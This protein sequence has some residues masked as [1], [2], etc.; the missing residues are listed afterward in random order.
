MGHGD[1]NWAPA[2]ETA[3]MCARHLLVVVSSPPLAPMSSAA[4]TQDRA[5]TVRW[6]PK[7]LRRTTGP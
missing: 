6:G 3:G 5:P 1:G 7:G 2:Q 4:G